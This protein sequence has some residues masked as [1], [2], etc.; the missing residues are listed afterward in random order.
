MVADTP[1]Q[2]RVRAADVLFAAFLLAYAAVSFSRI[3]Y[4]FTDLS[5]LF[6]LEQDRWVMQEWVHPIYVPTLA[7]LRAV[8]GW[9]HYHGRMLVP[10][11]VVSL[12]ASTT[13]WVVLY[14]LA[15][16]F[17]G[18]SLAAAVAL[19]AAA[20]CSG[21]WQAAMR[22]TPYGL[23]FMCQTLSLSLL[24]SDVPVPPGRYAW[25]GG[26]AGVAMGFHAAAMAL[27]AAAVVC[28]MCEPDPMR[29]PRATLMR[30]RAFGG[31]MVAVIVVC[32]AVFFWYHGI[33]LAY[34]RNLDFSSLFRGVEQV[35]NT[36][37][38]TSRS[39]TAQLSTF[40]TMLLFQAGALLRIAVVIGVGMAVYRLFTRRALTAAERRLAV[41]AIAG[42]FL[43]NNSHNGFIFTSLSFAPVLVAVLTGDSWVAFAALLFLATSDLHTNV[44][45]TLASGAAGSNDPQ[46]AE[47]RFLEQVLGPR[48]VVLVP[49]SP[50]SE[51]LYLGH[52]T[53]FELS[54]GGT[55]SNAGEAPVVGPGPTLR[56]RVGWWIAKGGHVFYA[57]GDDSSDFTGDVSGAEKGRQIFWRPETLARERAA[58]LQAL[59]TGL[60]RSGLELR[61][62]LRSPQDRRYAEVRLRQPV[63]A[64]GVPPPP[65]TPPLSLAEL[66]LRFVN[67]DTDGGVQ[68]VLARRAQYLG[69]IAAA[70]PD[71]PWLACDVMELVCKGRPRS[72]S[73]PV[74]CQALPGCDPPRG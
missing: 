19:A 36:S 13:A 22:P 46:L 63:L 9:F 30:I 7:L 11:E 26:L 40:G 62:G 61:E 55:S 17:P 74:P 39:V 8:L 25:A 12:A 27:G 4:D 68:P 71:D 2:R 34:W 65:Q 73:G 10:V 28:A 43:I 37:I 38:Y 1:A 15:R 53:F 41:V 70:F 29:T 60:E 18:S 6:S 66:R 32:W 69:E 51:M 3:P 35:P 42:F 59:R 57:Q 21:F 49:G 44:N 67:G 5:Y 45:R 47:V 23:A 20:M 14:R 33:G 58:V 24:V 16:R 64:D 56:A 72:S 48:D 54:D 52:M 31:S 50:F